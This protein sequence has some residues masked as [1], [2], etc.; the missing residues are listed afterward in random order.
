MSNGM[1][2]E[3][4]RLY[5][6]QNAKAFEKIEFNMDKQTEVL[7]ALVGEVKSLSDGQKSMKNSLKE[8]LQIITYVAVVLGAAKIAWVGM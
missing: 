1:T 8:I 4:I 5:Q 2:K 6:E 3:M 7:H